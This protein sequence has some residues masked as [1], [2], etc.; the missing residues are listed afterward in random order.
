MKQVA[1]D[2]LY[3]R[4]NFLKTTGAA[5]MAVSFGGAARA[6][7]KQLNVY[8]W[9]TYIG[10]TTLDT[11]SNKTGV[12]VKYDL[13]ANLDDMFAKFKTGN[14][15]YDVIFPSDYMIETMIKSDML[16]PCRISGAPSA[17][18]TGRRRSRA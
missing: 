12:E 14:P 10:E 2:W 13:Y 9:D 1:A 5:A 11:F 16:L 6:A 18:A 15:G 17:S 8:N 7:S 3:S 4:R